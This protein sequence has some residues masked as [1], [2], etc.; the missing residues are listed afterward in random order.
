MMMA[1]APARGGT[2]PTLC[3][4][5]GTGGTPGRRGAAF[6]TRGGGGRRDRGEAPRE[7]SPSTSQLAHE[8]LGRLVQAAVE[9]RYATLS[10]GERRVGLAL[11]LARSVRLETHELLPEVHTCSSEMVIPPY[12]TREQLQ[13]RLLFALDNTGDA[14]A[15]E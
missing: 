11:D 2:A 5:L 14:F 6:V 8:E 3:P 15:L 4:R 12:D 10:E 1:V 7:G 9:D 13:E